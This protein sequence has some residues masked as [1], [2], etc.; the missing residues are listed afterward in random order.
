MR[1]ASLVIIGGG[2]TGNRFEI[3]QPAVLIGR[4]PTSELTL[5]DDGVSREHAVISC[6]DDHYGIEDLQSSNGT[7]VNGKR[8]RSS[9]LQDGDEIQVGSTVFLF[10]LD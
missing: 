4:T 10:R 3:V 9:E 5:V 1:R 6:D 7:H 8:V 2:F